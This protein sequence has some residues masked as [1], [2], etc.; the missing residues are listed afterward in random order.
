MSLSGRS[1]AGKSAAGNTAA[2][3][4]AVGIVAADSNC[5]DS[6]ACHSGSNKTP[7]LWVLKIPA[8]A[9]HSQAAQGFADRKFAVAQAAAEN[10][11]GALN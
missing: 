7:P 8:A 9:P 1:Q 10:P 5:L 2:G 3:S 11:A 4:G 6:M